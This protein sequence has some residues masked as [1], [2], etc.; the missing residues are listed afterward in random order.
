MTSE[1]KEKVM[2]DW[3]GINIAVERVIATYEYEI[4]R[5]KLG[6]SDYIPLVKSVLLSAGTVSIAANYAKRVKDIRANEKT[7]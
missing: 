7:S 6:S 2:I 4:L 3:C 5:E 1:V